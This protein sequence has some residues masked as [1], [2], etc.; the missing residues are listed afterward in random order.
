MSCILRIIGKKLDAEKLAKTLTIKP[1]KIFKKGDPIFESKPNGKKLSFSGMAFV[2]SKA[3]FD[4]LKKQIKDS[5]RFLSRNKLE[6]KK[7]IRNKDIEYAVLDF[8]SKLRIGKDVAIQS[9]YFPF[10]LLKLA[11][12]LK[13]GIE[14]SLYDYK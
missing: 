10:E 3:D 2:V 4:Q 13:I 11:G 5:T 12:D 7:I 14:I 9:D 8:G 6:L 1:Y